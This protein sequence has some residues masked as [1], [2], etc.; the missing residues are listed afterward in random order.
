MR[1]ASSRYKSIGLSWLSLW[2][3][4]MSSPA[5]QT[6]FFLHY[7]ET[8]S[9]RL[10]GFPHWIFLFHHRLLTSSAN[11]R[12][13]STCEIAPMFLWNLNLQVTLLVQ[14]GVVT[15][16]H[17]TTPLINIKHLNMA[18]ILTQTEKLCV[19]YSFFEEILWKFRIWWNVP[20]HINR[21]SN[22]ANLPCVSSHW[23]KLSSAKTDK[24]TQPCCKGDWW[25]PPR[26]YWVRNFLSWRTLSVSLAQRPEVKVKF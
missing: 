12:I 23:G 22:C 11:L 18:T 20:K 4:E 8:L 19:F 3:S 2:H 7:C 10:Q 26:V 21:L 9:I 6:K 25:I 15:R 16:S 13:A 1:N 24:V 17:P 14:K 5:N